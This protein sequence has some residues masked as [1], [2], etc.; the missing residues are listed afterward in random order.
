MNETALVV[1]ES[2]DPAVLFTDAGMDEVLARIKSEAMSYAFTAEDEQGRKDIT[3]LAYRVARS[4]TIIDD[5][6]KDIVSEWKRQSKVY[7]V[8]R[9]KARDFLD[10]LKEEVQEPLTVWKAE[11]ARLKAEEERREREKIDARIVALA[12]VGCVIGSFEITAMTDDEFDEKLA[13]V[14]SEHEEIQRIE[15]EARIAA[16]AARKAEEEKLAAERAELNAMRAEQEKTRKEQEE[17]D[18]VEREKMAEEAHKLGAQWEAIRLEKERI[19]R[20]KFEAQAKEDARMEAERLAAEKFERED[21]EKRKAEEQALTEKIRQ[22]ALLPDKEKL[23]AWIHSFTGMV[24]PDVQDAAA[25]EIVVW[26]ESKISELAYQV[27]DK[28]NKL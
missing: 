4:K 1:R 25:Q 27:I 28:I 2:L 14:T 21:R 6:G 18:R 16:E 13:V 7:D 5:L 15:Q 22:E 19:D 23:V 24:S 12:Q 8:Q 11:Q 17:K 9:K 3:S 10:A 20:E 26:F